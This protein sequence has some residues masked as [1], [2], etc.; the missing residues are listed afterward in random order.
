MNNKQ[1]EINPFLNN[2][3]IQTRDISTYTTHEG[4]FKNGVKENVTVTQTREVE[5]Y[6][7]TRVYRNKDNS[8]LIYKLSPPGLKLYVYIIYNI[9]RNK[10]KIELRAS[11]VCK[12]L[13]ISDK[14]FS[15]GIKA[16]KE[17]NIIQRYYGRKNM[18]W[19]NTNYLYFGERIR[20]M[21]SQYGEHVILKTGKNDYADVF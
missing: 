16:L 10:D 13:N 12:D 14:T 1:D 8:N 21:E 18:W 6:K 4:E 17:S 20:F 3:P 19:L 5:I 7:A 15:R 9:G 11:K 2:N